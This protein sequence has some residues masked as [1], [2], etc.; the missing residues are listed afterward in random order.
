MQDSGPRGPELETTGLY[1][2][3]VRG[4]Q[5]KM[6]IKDILSMLQCFGNGIPSMFPLFPCPYPI[7]IKWLATPVNPEPNYMERGVKYVSLITSPFSQKIRT[8]SKGE[9]LALQSQQSLAPNQSGILFSVT[10]HC[11]EADAPLSSKVGCKQ[12]AERKIQKH[13]LAS[14][15]RKNKIKTHECTQT[16]FTQ[17]FCSSRARECTGCTFQH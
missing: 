9:L 17:T 14:T 1:N 12:A 16:E 4:K 8:L 7:S 10:F 3:L 11:C 13:Q 2:L 6:V 15:F 5:V